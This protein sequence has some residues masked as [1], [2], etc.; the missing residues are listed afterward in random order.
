[1]TLIQEREKSHFKLGGIEEDT[2]TDC[3]ASS[4]MNIYLVIRNTNY[5]HKYPINRPGCI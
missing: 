4:Q 1:M 5:G 3:S 2:Q